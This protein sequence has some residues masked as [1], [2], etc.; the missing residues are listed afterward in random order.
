M[1]PEWEKVDNG[2]ILTIEAESCEAFEQQLVVAAAQFPDGVVF[3]RKVKTQYEIQ[4]GK[5]LARF[6]QKFIAGIELHS[7]TVVDRKL[8]MGLKSSVTE[9]LACV[10]W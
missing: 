4:A 2:L 6:V 9:L 5:E 8:L 10:L 3:E 7:Q 1:F